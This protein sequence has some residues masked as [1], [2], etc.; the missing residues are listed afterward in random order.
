[1]GALEADAGQG[2]W[3]SLQ[4]GSE[5]TVTTAGQETRAAMAD[6]G[7]QAAMAVFSLGKV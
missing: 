1:M 4:G 5:A 6:T 7:I 3:E 2:H